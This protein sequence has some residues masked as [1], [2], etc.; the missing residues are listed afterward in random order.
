[1]KRFLLF[2]LS[3]PLYGATL[4]Y[5]YLAV[6]KTNA[7][8]VDPTNFISGNALLTTNAAAAT[9]EPL[10][11]NKY[12]ATNSVLTTL[13]T[14]NGG[15]LTNLN[16]VSI[17]AGTINSN[18]VDAATISLFT[19][20][21]SGG[22]SVWFDGTEVAN[23]DFDS[24]WFVRNSVTGT[25]RVAFP[26]AVVTAS[27]TNFTPNLGTSLF[28]QYTLTNNATLNAPTG[29]TSDHVGSTFR[30]QLI[31]NA[32]GGYSITVSTNDY[33]PND[34]TPAAV[35][36]RTNANYRAMLIGFVSATNRIDMLSF[37]DGM[38]P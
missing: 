13:V 5:T 10:N 32:T 23:P 21:G 31:E 8:I 29:V 28:F 38:V 27:G 20:G 3:L 35:I 19:A 36:V 15:S 26:A 9:Y 1:M 12:Q 33:K 18:S 2:F 22:G 7:T 6:D 14:L 37:I 30:I 17:Q 25:N 24:N 11:A 4:P 16:G 34:L